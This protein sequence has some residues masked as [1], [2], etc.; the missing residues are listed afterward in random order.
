M[1]RARFEDIVAGK[2]PPVFFKRKSRAGYV[3]PAAET[4]SV[5]SLAD[6]CHLCFRRCQA[7]RFH[8]ETGYCGI[9]EGGGNVVGAEV[10]CNEEPV[11]NPTFEVFLSGCNVRC[12]FCYQSRQNQHPR[13]FPRKPSEQFAREIESIVPQRARNLHWV[14]G[15]PT[16][17]LPWILET[18]AALEKPVPVIWNSNMSMHADTREALEGIVDI[19]LA[20]IHFGND[21]CASRMGAVPGFNQVVKDNIIYFSTRTDMIVR[22]LFLPGHFDCCFKPIINWCRTF[23]PAV[24]VHIMPQYIP[25]PQPAKEI[26]IHR[27]SPTEFARAVAFARKIGVKLVERHFP[28]NPAPEALQGFE[29]EISIFPDGTVSIKNFSE[30]FIELACELNYYKVSPG[31]SKGSVNE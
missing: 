6:P 27:T 23:I 24:P 25:P 12:G 30:D 14:G 15:E 21:R 13:T 18:M 7:R 8:G 4:R 16:L 19:F 26:P 3:D 17:H 20:D 10:L 29:T 31:V 11:L 28:E 22:Y 9:T 2:I 5:R 1:I